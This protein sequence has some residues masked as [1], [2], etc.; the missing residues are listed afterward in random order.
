[1]PLTTRKIAEAADKLEKK[2]KIYQYRKKYTKHLKIR[3]TAEN[4]DKK[5]KNHKRC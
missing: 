5:E 3:K 2:F 1:M 4:A